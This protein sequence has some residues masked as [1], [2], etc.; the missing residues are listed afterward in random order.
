[1][2]VAN[3]ICIYVDFLD[4][5]HKQ[6]KKVANCELALTQVQVSEVRPSRCYY[7]QFMLK[8]VHEFLNGIVMRSKRMYTHKGIQ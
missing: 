5:I 8:D 3:H 7:Y 6:S 4:T 2:S 1:M